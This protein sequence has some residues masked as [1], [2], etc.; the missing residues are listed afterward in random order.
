MALVHEILSMM[1]EKKIVVDYLTHFSKEY[2]LPHSV[3]SLALRHP[4]IFYVSRK[5]GRFTVFLKE[6]YIGG[7]L[8]KRN[9]WNM[10]KDQYFDLINAKKLKISDVS[11][12]ME[13]SYTYDSDKAQVRGVESVIQRC[14]ADFDALLAL[15][16][17]MKKSA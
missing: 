15:C 14:D 8:I 11:S 4:S 10:L 7:K 13:N 1:T 2:R 5:G 16:R 9:E 17:K 12:S 3:L 6:T